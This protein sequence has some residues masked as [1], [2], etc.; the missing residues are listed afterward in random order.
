MATKKLPPKHEYWD[1]ARDGKPL[2][3][4]CGYSEEAHEAMV[5]PP[6]PAFDYEKSLVV[7]NKVFYVCW[8]LNP[9]SQAEQWEVLTRAGKVLNKRYPITEWDPRAFIERAEMFG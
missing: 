2:C 7:G 5:R 8:S 6:E 9:H 3:L 1:N 4:C